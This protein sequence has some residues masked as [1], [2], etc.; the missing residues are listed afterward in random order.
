LTLTASDAEFDIDQNI[1]VTVNHANRPPQWT[2][3]PGSVATDE[4]QELGFTVT[5]TDP[6]GDDLTVIASSDDLPAG[7][8]FTDNGDGMG[9]FTWTP[10]YDEAGVYE[11]DVTVSDA[12]YDVTETV[13]ITVGDINRTPIWVDIPA[14]VAVDEAQNL[15]FEVQASDPDA[16]DLTIQAV[17]GDLPGGWGFTDNGDGTGTFNWTP[18]Y[19]DAGEYTLTVTASDGNFNISSNINITVNQVNRAP[20][21]TAVPASATTNEN[22]LLT[23]NVVASDPDGDNLTLTASSGNLPGGWTFTDLGAGRGIFLWTPTYSHAGDYTLIVRV[24]DGGFNVDE[25]IAIHLSGRASRSAST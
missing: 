6:D 18:G 19:D 21:W 3:I 23:I 22:Q 8:E 10:G 17:S 12:E 14:N 20:S 13:S 5:A 24:T 11:L 15:E 16:D 7:W 1:T 9:S 25:D 2:D 4:N